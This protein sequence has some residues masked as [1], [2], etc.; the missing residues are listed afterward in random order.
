[1]LVLNIH[2]GGH[3]VVGV[4]CGQRLDR[5]YTDPA[6][7][8]LCTWA[9]PYPAAAVPAGYLASVLVGCAFIVCGFNE[10]A[11]KVA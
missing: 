6:E 10:L 9:G 2:E 11:S 1:M 3:I 7:G 5:I 8:G 4:L